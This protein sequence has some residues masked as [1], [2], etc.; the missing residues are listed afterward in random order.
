[1]DLGGV[2]LRRLYVADR[3]QVIALEDWLRMRVGS[4]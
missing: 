3:R 4:A 2:R 1:V